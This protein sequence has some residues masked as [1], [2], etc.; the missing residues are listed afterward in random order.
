M[1]MKKIISLLKPGGIAIITVP[2]GYNTEIDE[3]IKNNRILFKE[4]YF[5]ERINIFNKW[6]STNIERALQLKYGQRY[7]AANSVAFLL[8]Y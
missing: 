5:L 8:Y 6:R 7:A 4:K 3:I 1:A 2:L